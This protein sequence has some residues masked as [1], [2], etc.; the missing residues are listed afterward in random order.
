[1]RIFLSTSLAS[2]VLTQRY[3]DRLSLMPRIFWTLKKQQVTSLEPST[4]FGARFQ[5]H[6]VQGKSFLFGC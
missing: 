2:L 4:D 1:M 6:E 5:A 3:L